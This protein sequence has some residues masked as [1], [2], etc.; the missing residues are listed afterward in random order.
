[1]REAVEIGKFY[2]AYLNHGA[3][4]WLK[5]DLHSNAFGIGAFLIFW[6][7]LIILQPEVQTYR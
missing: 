2:V 4:I 7:H 3:K 6:L 1:V 5:V